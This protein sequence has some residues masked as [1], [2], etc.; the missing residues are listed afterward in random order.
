MGRAIV[1][2]TGT[3]TVMKLFDNEIIS[4]VVLLICGIAGLMLLLN[5]RGK[6]ANEPW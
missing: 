3:L 6:E 2:I 1:F 5:A 4:L